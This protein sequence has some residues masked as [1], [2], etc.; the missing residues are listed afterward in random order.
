MIV[1]DAEARAAMELT[2]TISSAETARLILAMSAGHASVKKFLCYEPEQKTYENQLYPRAEASILE[3]IEG[4][5]DVDTDRRRAVWEA[6]NGI[7][8]FLQLEH[9]PVR[10]VTKVEVDPSA[11]FGQRS[12][13]FG[14]G[15]GWT[16]GM[17]YVVEWDEQYSG[18]NG[19]SRT[20][21]L[22]AVGAWP[23]TPGTVRVSYVAGYSP[24]EFAGQALATNLDDGGKITGLG[25]DAS[26]IK[27]AV[28]LEVIRYYLLF[29]TMSK[30]ALT[31]LHVAGPLQSERLGDYSYS[32]A[33][34]A[35]VALLTGM[36]IAISPE[37]AMLCEQFQHYGVMLL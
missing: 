27:S 28:L 25:V 5:W 33:S 30:N 18:G 10:Q 34:G 26:P 7:F 23:I 32:L 2:A 35:Q 22:I 9:L 15:S 13:D 24:T 36:Q 29:K 21:Q 14:T 31:G 37:A 16:A 20:G 6:R 3:T 1:T 17:E 19:I 12:G 11:L 4:I 8:N